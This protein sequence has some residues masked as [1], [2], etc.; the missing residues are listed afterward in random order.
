VP[1]ALLDLFG[2]KKQKTK[3]LFPLRGKNG[4]SI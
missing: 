2:N 1:Q 4:N 3:R